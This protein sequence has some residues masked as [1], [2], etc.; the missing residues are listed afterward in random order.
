MNINK[1]L[2]EADKIKINNLNKKIFEMWEQYKPT[3]ASD[4]I[5]PLPSFFRDNFET[6]QLLLIGMNPS[7]NDEYVEDD[8]A[9]KKK[10]FYHY[11]TQYGSN[12]NLT[13]LTELQEYENRIG[14]YHSYEKGINR[15][16]DE[17][18]INT[19]KIHAIDLFFFRKTNQ[20]DFLKQ[21]ILDKSGNLT[22]LAIEMFNITLKAI[23]IYK[24]KIIVIANANAFKLFKEYIMSLGDPYYITSNLDELH[25]C[26]FVTLDQHQGGIPVLGSSM[27]SGQRALDLGSKER[28]AWQIRRIYKNLVL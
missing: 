7:L 11:C 24:P 27:L 14:Q 23:I 22:L 6:N 5:Y 19:L 21:H 1:V 13:K 2:N 25:G 17:I 8:N 3:T 9:K 4:D 28:M 15:F 26:H 16:K 12:W 20:S 10:G 18:N